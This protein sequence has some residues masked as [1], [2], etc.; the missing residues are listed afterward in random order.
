MDYK[1]IIS[2][3][4]GTLL[5]SEHEIPK[6]NLEALKKAT[7][8]GMPVVLC[9]GRSKQSVQQITDLLGLDQEHTYGA[10]YHGSVIFN[11]KTNEIVKNYKINKNLIKDILELT[12]G[13]DFTYLIHDDD[14]LYTFNANQHTKVYEE[15]CGDVVREVKFE[16]LNDVVSK[17]IIMG[18]NEELVEFEKT[19][20]KDISNNCTHFFASGH[21]YEFIHEDA[22]KGN[23]LKF[24]CDKLGI[25]QSETIGFGDNFNDMAL[26]KEAGLGVAV[27]NAV[28]DLKAA[29]DYVTKRNNDESALEEVLNKFVFKE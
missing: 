25:N 22:S 15:R 6:G 16:D 11:S 23:A 28:P 12:K 10:G 29:A 3:I 13:Y 20:T 9:S 26:V 24:L 2:D 7:N 5:N 4:D 14:D 27:A 8:M 19:I 21:L 17:L 18:T 1:M